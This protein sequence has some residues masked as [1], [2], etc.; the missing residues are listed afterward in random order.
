M[1]GFYIPSLDA[2]DIYLQGDDLRISN[3]KY[4]NSFDYSLDMIELKKISERKEWKLAKTDEFGKSYS[5][6]IMNITFKYSV[7]E[8][9]MVCPKYYVRYGYNILQSDLEDWKAYKDGKL[10]AIKVEEPMQ[11]P[12]DEDLL[13]SYFKEEYAETNHTY[14]YYIGCIPTLVSKSKLRE[15][16]YENGFNYNGRHYCRF[17]RSS[18][19]AR[20][21]KCLFIDDR[22]YK[23]MHRFEQ[24]GL[25]VKRG[26]DIDLASFEAY[27]SLLTSSIVDT[28]SI[29]PDNILVVDDYDSVFNDDAV[30]TEI[31]SDGMLTT[32][33]KNISITNCIWDGQSLIDVSLMGKYA[34]K[35]MILLRNKFFKSC[36]F[37]TNI[38]Q[39]F[40]DHNITDISQINGRTHATRIEDIKLITTP[41]SI[42]FLKFGDFD[43]WLANICPYFG[44]VKFDKP[45]HF[46]DGRLV[47]IHYQLINTL[48][49]SEDEVQA[50]LQDDL[51]Y[52]NLI[53]SDPDA[54][55]FHLGLDKHIT[56]NPHS[57]MRTKS[58][59]VY[60]MLNY[61]CG[62]EHTDLYKNFKHDITK[63]MYKDLRCG[64]VL[65]NGTY[66]TLSGNPYEMLLQS[67]GQFDGTPLIGVGCVHSKR[68]EYNKTI[69][70]S[71]SPHVTIGNILLA[72]NIESEEIDKYFNFT[73]NIIVLNSIGD[74]ILQR[75]SGCDYDGDAMLITDNPILIR[76]AQKNYDVFKVPSSEVHS[77]KKKRKYTAESLADLDIKTGT[78]KIGE[79]VNLSQSL[80][81]LLWDKVNKT[82]KDAKD[83]FDEIKDIYYDVCQLDVMSGIEIDKA[84][85][86]VL[87]DNEKELR[88]MRQKY[89]QELTASDDRKILPKF[90]GFI[91][92][93]KG[94]YDSK[95]KDYQM[96]QTS[97]DYVWHIVN[98]QRAPR[99]NKHIKLYDIFCIDKDESSINTYSV[100]RLTE[101]T[102]EYITQMAAVYLKDISYDEK[103]KLREEIRINTMN[104]INKLKINNATFTT[105][106]RRI[107]KNKA[108]D[109]LFELL[110]NYKNSI[111]KDAIAKYPVKNV[112]FFNEKDGI[113][114][115]FGERYSKKPVFMGVSEES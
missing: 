5:S 25:N 2:K 26:D 50:L 99:D 57:I 35:G 52:I 4:I 77:N 88:K 95:K 29:S 70:G 107:D 36:C 41:S 97:M 42:K 93:T 15:L 14:K 87:V 17:K 58:D 102:S 85:K 76:S 68:F 10:V 49:M 90:L 62:F 101:I 18:G 72:K 6:E 33:E 8:F 11:E 12:I 48:Q 66:A 103:Q 113:Y 40:K 109:K 110:F 13:P 61:D 86:E 108:T 89:A 1:T 60:Q 24:C 82:G 32:T 81:S 46:F 104:A 59:I 71:R 106:I 22:Y 64:H 43:T 44:V 3:H 20:V 69:L 37:N 45:T 28:I 78:N 67:I 84:K 55:R 65:V 21:G 30:V 51:D 16:L 47:Q 23:P 105:C 54:M 56:E 111:I 27:I 9:N 73:D 91:A 38:Q 115:I 31:G 98:K 92:R 114:N 75:L 79:I 96:H 53:N 94:Y 83:C 63:S 80:N 100:N 112:R 19:S 74:N 34:D 39:F 7:H